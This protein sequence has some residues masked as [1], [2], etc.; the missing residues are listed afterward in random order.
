MKR[1]LFRSAH[2]SYSFSLLTVPTETGACPSW[3]GAVSVLSCV[4]NLWK[5]WLWALCLELQDKPCSS[6]QEKV[7]LTA[8]VLN[9]QQATFALQ[10]FPYLFDMTFS[11][12]RRKICS[13]EWWGTKYQPRCWP[14]PHWWSRYILIAHSSQL[15]LHFTALCWSWQPPL[16][17]GWW[18]WVQ[19]CR[20]ATSNPHS[21]VCHM[22]SWVGLT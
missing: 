7:P 10:V 12:R 14:S 18:V 20:K 5:I 17:A 19:Y 11:R 6:W 3:N 1:A 9:V 16:R 21:F 8:Q 13:S 22:D 2:G 15:Q 4:D